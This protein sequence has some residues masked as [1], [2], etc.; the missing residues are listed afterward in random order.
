MLS[1]KYFTK[2][3]H[4]SSF[5]LKT[6][7][8]RLTDIKRGQRYMRN[9]DS[10]AENQWLS[11]VPRQTDKR[12][13]YVAIRPI[14]DSVISKIQSQR[15]MQDD[16]G[17]NS[18]TRQRTYSERY[19]PSEIK[20]IYADELALA[21]RFSNV[22][23]NSSSYKNKLLTERSYQSPEIRRGL[24]QP[25]ENIER[26][27]FNQ[28]GSGYTPLDSVTELKKHDLQPK[29]EPFRF[30]ESIQRVVK[31]V[32]RKSVPMSRVA[33][34]DKTRQSRITT[35]FRSTRNGTVKVIRPPD[36][37]PEAP[38]RSA[39]DIVF[40]GGGG[41]GIKNEKTFILLRRVDNLLNPDRREQ[42]SSLGSSEKDFPPSKSPCISDISDPPSDFLQIREESRGPQREI[43]YPKYDNVSNVPIYPMYHKSIHHNRTKRRNSLTGVLNELK[44]RPIEAMRKCKIWVNAITSSQEQE[45]ETDISFANH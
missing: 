36:P 6:K 16:I 32:P 21:H 25:V 44:E 11:N 41:S 7:N 29:Y 8:R 37:L 9:I 45:D 28:Y 17:V 18:G 24:L 14:T 27:M 39:V 2:E 12:S 34:D 26:R 3:E 5:D 30:R 10:L 1:D 4:K 43:Y 15:L 31:P 35:D 13:R 20:R 19:P 33:E 23:T 38:K 40:G 22:S 42:L